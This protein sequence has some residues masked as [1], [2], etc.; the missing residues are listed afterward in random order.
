MGV[1]IDIF[2]HGLA[3][4][5]E[6]GIGVIKVIVIGIFK[7]GMTIEILQGRCVVDVPIDLA[8]NGPMTKVLVVIVT[9]GVRVV[10]AI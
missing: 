10:R 2:Q 7:I 9:V 6:L 8:L 3:I 4:L 5:G 1:I